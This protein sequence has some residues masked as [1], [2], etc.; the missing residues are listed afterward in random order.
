MAGVTEKSMN[1][2][3]GVI[4]LGSSLVCV[5]AEQDGMDIDSPVMSTMTEMLRQYLVKPTDFAEAQL[6][7]ASKNFWKNNFNWAPKDPV[8]MLIMASM[9]VAIEQKPFDFISLFCHIAVSYCFILS[10]YPHLYHRLVRRLKKPQ[11]RYYQRHV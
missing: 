11:V 9:L 10:E 4:I 1:K 6:E 3:L 8:L 7:R 5:A 2:L